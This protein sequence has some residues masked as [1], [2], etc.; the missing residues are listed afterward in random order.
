MFSGIIAA[1]GRIRTPVPAGG[2]PLTIEAP[3]DA[4]LGDSIAVSGVCLTVVAKA[5]GLMTFDVSPETLAVTTI[6]TLKAG[7]AVNL[8]EALRLGDRLGGHIVQGHVDGLAEI[9]ALTPEGNGYR[10]AITVPKTLLRYVAHK[11]S[12]TVGG[13][14]LTVAALQGAVAEFAIIPYTYTHTDLHERRRGDKV[15]L[16]VDVLAR[17]LEALSRGEE[18]THD[19]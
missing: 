13:I 8:E 18:N 11:G 9:T 2:G 5:P 3:L 17:Y 12:L 6:G 4:V 15:N 7:D 16:E 1:V 10:L 14:S 19:V